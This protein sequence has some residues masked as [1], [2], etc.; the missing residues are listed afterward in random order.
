MFSDAVF[1]HLN[2]HPE[3][4]PFPS[5]AFEELDSEKPQIRRPAVSLCQSCFSSS[6]AV[7]VGAVAI[8]ALQL[9]PRLSPA[10]SGHYWGG[11]AVSSLAHRPNRLAM[12]ERIQGFL[13]APV[14]ME[15]N[16]ILAVLAEWRESSKLEA[17]NLAVVA[18]EVW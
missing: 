9:L 12:V 18:C 15:T 8:L 3:L 11:H 1:Y 10:R 2:L 17:Q 14:C 13:L 6:W 16:L 5:Q 4:R 7:L